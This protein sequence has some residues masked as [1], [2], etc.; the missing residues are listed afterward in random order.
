MGLLP[1]AQLHN[2]SSTS[3]CRLFG[4]VPKPACRRKIKAAL[5]QDAVTESLSGLFPGGGTLILFGYTLRSNFKEKGYTFFKKSRTLES[6]K[7]G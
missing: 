5:G 1:T 4:N 6:K 2:R 3:H 7:K